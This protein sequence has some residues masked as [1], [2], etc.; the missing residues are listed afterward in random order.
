MVPTRDRPTF[1]FKAAIMVGML[2]G[3][4]TFQ[5]TCPL[6]APKVRTSFTL[7]G[8]TSLK[9]VCIIIMVTMMETAMAMA[10]TAVMVVPSQTTKMGPRA[11]LGMLL[12]TTM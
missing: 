6:L 1:T 2:A 5:R 7:L 12:S 11:T 8:S 10:T 9:P 4:I 3:M